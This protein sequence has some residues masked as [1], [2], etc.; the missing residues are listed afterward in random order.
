MLHG[1]QALVGLLE[2]ERDLYYDT[3]IDRIGRLREMNMAPSRW[4]SHLAFAAAAAGFCW[5]IAGD[6]PVGHGQEAKENPKL[7]GK[8]GRTIGLL[9]ARGQNFIEVKAD[10]E[11]K[12]RRYVPRWVGGS[13]ADG[14]GLDKRMLKTFESL[15]IGSRLQVDWIYEERLRAIA[16]KVLQEPEKKE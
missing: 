4:W 14:G 16:V 12:G 8:K 10:G 13:P 7:T 2:R 1:Q 5:I 9:T 6:I 11:V 3:A 15:K